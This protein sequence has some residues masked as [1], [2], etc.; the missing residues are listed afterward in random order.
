MQRR[1]FLQNTLGVAAVSV[2]C[3]GKEKSMTQLSDTVPAAVANCVTTSDGTCL[4]IRFRML[5]TPTFRPGM[6]APG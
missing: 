3:G 6:Q 1:L 4:F 5:K 2:I